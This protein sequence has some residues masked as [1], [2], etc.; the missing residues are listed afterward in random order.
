MAILALAL[1]VV[2]FAAGVAGI[3]LPVLPGP[4][5]IWLGMLL[6]GLLTGFEHISWMFLLL[7]AALVA[8]TFVVD[9]LANA[10][11]VR[12]FGGSRAAIW[13]GGIGLLLGAFIFGPAGIVLGPFAGAFLGELLTGRHPAQAFRAGIGTL[14]GFAGGTAIKLCIA[15]GMITWFFITAY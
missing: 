11:G 5:L 2:C 9:Y 7:Q 14:L 10:W 12:R 3:I 1:A 8:L 4:P 13:G 15:A 6:Y